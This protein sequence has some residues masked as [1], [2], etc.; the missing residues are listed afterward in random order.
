M[1]D[2]HREVWTPA[3]VAESHVGSRRIAPGIW[4]DR[5]GAMHFSVPE[6][7]AVL[8][9]PDDAEH[10]ALVMQAIHEYC[11]RTFPGTSVIETELES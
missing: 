9:W 5:Q 3:Q 11:E 2:R 1:S 6:L 4:V 7:L 10:R 8:G